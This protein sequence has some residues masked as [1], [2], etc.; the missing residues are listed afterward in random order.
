M[1]NRANEMRAKLTID[2]NA[3]DGTT[4]QLIVKP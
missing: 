4:I 1:Q 2:S 3:G